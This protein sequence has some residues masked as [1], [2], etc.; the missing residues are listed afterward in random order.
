MRLPGKA[1]CWF[2]TLIIF[3]TCLLF[4]TSTPGDM[5]GF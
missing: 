3:M 4:I 5:A 1:T 2:I